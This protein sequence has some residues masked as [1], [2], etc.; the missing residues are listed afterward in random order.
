MRKKAFLLCALLVVVVFL[1]AQDLMGKLADQLFAPEQLIIR[2][3][4]VKF[5]PDDPGYRSDVEVKAE[6]VTVYETQTK[7]EPGDKIRIRYDRLNVPEQWDG[8]EPITLVEV[9]KEYHAYLAT[10]RYSFYV[11]IAGNA[12]FASYEQTLYLELADIQ[13]GV[14]RIQEK[15]ASVEKILNE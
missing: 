5:Q 8:A 2:I 10:Y 13:R 15:V 4:D 7:L 12:S 11:P 3:T 9:G 1:Q 6:V 14:Q